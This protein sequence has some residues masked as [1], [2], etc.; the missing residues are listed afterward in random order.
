VSGKELKGRVALITGA[1]SGIGRAIALLFAREGAKIVVADISEAD[2]EKSVE[3]IKKA[4]GEGVFVKG[5]VSKAEVARRMT[6][7]AVGEYGRL[8]ILCN[9]AGI[10]SV[11]TVVDVGEEKWDKVINVNLKGA[12]LCSKYAIPKI[13]ESGGGVVINIASVLGLIG[14]KGEAAYCASKGA[15]VSLT[16]AM[17][18]DFASQNVRVNCIC[19]GS[20]LTPTFRRVIASSGDYERAFKKNLEKIPLKRVAEPEEIA[21][22]ALYLASDKSSYVTGSALVIDGGWSIS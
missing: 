13:I 16:R 7:A 20:V 15:I 12:F 19:P 21:Y 4:D 8:D 1:G 10:E 18:L 22:A 6:D 17:A 5:D 9:N 11:G 3:L 14:S 2:G